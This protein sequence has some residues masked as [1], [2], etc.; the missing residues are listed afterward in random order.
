MADNLNAK[1]VLECSSISITPTA[2]KILVGRHILVIP[3]ILATCGISL[4]NG[5]EYINYSKGAF[6]ANVMERFFLGLF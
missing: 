4:A 3:D 1:I 5:L 2:H 6:D